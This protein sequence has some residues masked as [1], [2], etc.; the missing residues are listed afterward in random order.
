MMSLSA[1]SSA[2][3]SRRSRRSLCSG[4]R[5]ISCRSLEVE[6]GF[7]G[8]FREGLD[9]AVKDVAAAIEHDLGDALVHRALGD[10]GAD[11]GGGV[12]VRALLALL[13]ERRGVG[14]RDAAGIVDHL[15]VDV[16]GRAEHRQTRTTLANLLQAKADAGGAALG[17]FA[18]GK[19]HVDYFFLPSLRRTFSPA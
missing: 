13:F 10:Q 4:P 16:L 8:C 18:V 5:A 1:R 19:R 2:L 11:A 3:R 7:A 6:A 15:G 12:L 17:G 14:E 9:A